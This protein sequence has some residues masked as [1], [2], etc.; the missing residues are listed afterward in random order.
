MILSPTLS[1]VA[2]TS[3]QSSWP[4][5]SASL[6]R[7][8]GELCLLVGAKMA[9][10]L[11][12]H[13]LL[14]HRLWWLK[15]TAL[16]NMGDWEELEKFSKSKKSPIGYLVRQ[17]RELFIH[18]GGGPREKRSQIQLIVPFVFQFS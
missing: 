3:V 16:A 15:L 6:T 14:S 5:I 13:A 11:L 8:R 17:N 12:L 18:L 9:S 4:E 2:T 1:S 10:G 7:G